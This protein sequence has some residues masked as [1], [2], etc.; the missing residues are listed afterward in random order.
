MDRQIIY[1][2][3]VPLDTDQLLQ[4][5][6]TMVALGYLTK[7]IVGDRQPYADGLSCSPGTGLNVM[8]G[9]GS[10]TLPTT[11]DT[12]PYGIL[13]PDGDL[14]LKTG[15]NTEPTVLPI[16]PSGTTLISA[17]VIEMQSGSQAVAYYNASNPTQT[18]FGLSGSGLAQATVVQ[19]R[20]DLVATSPS[21]V[22][23]GHIP[24]WQVTVAV[25][26]TAVT[27]DMITVA[28][29]APFIQVKLPFAAPLMSPAFTGAPTCPTA[30]AGDAT[31]A[32]ATTA[33]VAT[34]TTRN[35]SAWGTGGSYTWICP[36]G[37]STI[38]IRAWAAGG[39]GGDAGGGSPGGG[40]GGGGFAEVL[41]NVV[42]GT[43]YTITVGS[44]TE[45]TTSTSFDTLVII[46]G[47]I[48][49]VSGKSGQ[50]GTGGAAGTPTTNNINSVATVGVGAGQDGY[51]LAGVNVGGAG[52]ASFGVQGSFPCIG[53]T[54]GSSG[55]WPGGG[56]SGGA[57]GS[58][59]KGA[60][61]LM[62][63]EWIG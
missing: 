54:A 28:Q 58:G 14:L 51:Q 40:G 10:M 48:N 44:G 15:I 38:L 23:S 12:N 36:S 25:G 11:I 2:G 42:T 27:S 41:I 32:L 1:V 46:G 3:A 4:S 37:V 63:L 29:G 7:M 52:G 33:F 34:A 57:S 31:N 20:V 26:A 16:S 17:S 47:G 43:S 55:I 56:G 21:A 19:Q 6:N 50:V 49:G 13:P 39:T 45:N 18:L 30:S 62:I 9:E 22:P 8:I 61:G 24:L 60:D 5:R 59:G 53:G 35:R